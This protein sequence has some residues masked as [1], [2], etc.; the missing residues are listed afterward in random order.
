MNLPAVLRRWSF[1]AS[2]KQ[3]GIS[4]EAVFIRSKE[5]GTDPP[6]GGEL[7][8]ANITHEI[9]RLPFSISSTK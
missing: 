1:G 4:I 5:Q 3:R 2:D 8:E 6:W 7:G 9:P